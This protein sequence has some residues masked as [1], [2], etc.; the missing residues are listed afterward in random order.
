[1]NPVV[2]PTLMGGLGNRLFQ[3]AVSYSYAKKYNKELMISN[4]KIHNYENPH[5]VI[6]YL[7][8]VFSK[9]SK[10]EPKSYFRFIEPDHKCTSYIDLPFIQGNVHLTGYFQ[11]EKYFH[12]HRKEL[13]ELFVLPEIKKCPKENSLFIHVRRGDYTVLK[14]HGGYNYDIFYKN[15]LDF[16]S[17]KFDHLNIYVFSNDIQWCKKWDLLKKYD[18]FNFEYIETMNELE[19]LKFMTL[20]DKGGICANSSFSWWGAYLN[21]FN[22]KIV[23][24]PNQW[25]FT[26]PHS[27]YPHDIAFEGSVKLSAV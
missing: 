2:F 9:I 1:M 27:D 24:M 19:T 15:A 4:S 25:F 6:D 16:I 14:I 21:D 12:L 3:I 22:D 11:C 26:K 18:K 10:F 5:S 13:K 17:D 8:T 23:V 7:N 20:C